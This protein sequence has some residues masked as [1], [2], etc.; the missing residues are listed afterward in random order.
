MTSVLDALRARYLEGRL[1]LVVGMGVSHSGGLP[2]WNGLV[3]AILGEARA[4]ASGSDLPALARVDAALSRGDLTRA[5]AELQA[6]MTAA[7]Y[8]RAVSR[9]LDD[10]PRDVPPLA[11]ALA[12]LAPTLHAVVTTNLDRFLERAFAGAW[13]AYTLPSLD[14]GQQRHYVLHLHGRRH[15]RS[16]WVLTE[17]EG[18]VLMHDRPELQRFVEGL[19]RFHSLLFVGYG[20]RDPDFER[21]CRQARIFGRGQAPLHFALVPEGS[22]NRY[23]QDRLAAAGIELLTYPD[24]DGSHAGLLGLLHDL[25][26][27][28]SARTMAAPDTRPP[29]ARPPPADAASARSNAC[30]VHC[31]RCGVTPDDAPPACIGLAPAHDFIALAGLPY[32]RDCGTTP[33]AGPC[34]CTGGRPAHRFVGASA[35]PRCRRCGRT[36]GGRSNCVGLAPRHDFPGP[37]ITSASG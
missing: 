24:P 19:F 36:A 7:A 37:P 8:G 2:D 14:L 22:A 29:S 15:E 25:C 27:S 11:R 9:A 13:P 32:C 20:L 6:T 34:A 17:R 35:L 5:L 33:A 28:Q 3:R 30:E 18:E 26:A 23:E 21:L 4:D 16:T 12:G 1:V 10:G 31:V